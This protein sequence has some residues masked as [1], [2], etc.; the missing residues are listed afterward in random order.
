MKNILEY[1]IRMRRAMESYVPDAYPLAWPAGWRRTSSAGHISGRF[2]SKRDVRSTHNSSIRHGQMRKLTVSQAR[3]C[4]LEALRLLRVGFD[5]MGL[6]K[7]NCQR[8]SR[9]CS[10]LTYYSYTPRRK[11]AAA[12]LNGLF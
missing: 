8:H 12:L 3:D 9:H 7:K 2:N 6:L 5:R 4:V 11:M 10:E 1:P